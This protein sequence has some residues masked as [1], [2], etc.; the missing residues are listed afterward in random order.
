MHVPVGDGDEFA[1]GVARELIEIDFHD[2]SGSSFAVSPD[3]KRVLVN[4][5]VDVSFRDETP[6]TLVTGWAGEVSRVAGSEADR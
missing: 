2:A 6:V 4:K 5:P 1:P 3:G